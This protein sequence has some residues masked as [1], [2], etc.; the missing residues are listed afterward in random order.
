MNNYNS[1]LIKSRRSYNITEIASLFGVDRKTCQ[2][3]IKIDGLKPIERDESP[4]VMGDVLE[5]FLRE[6][7]KKRKVKLNEDEFYCMKCHK[8]VSVKI[9]TEKIIKT[10]KKIGRNDL[11]QFKKIGI[12]EVCETKVNRF[13][14]VCKQD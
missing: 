11:D 7:N 5:I 6:K 3:W 12:C 14:G 10:G 2:R 9:D 13:L 8:A 4:L 1:R